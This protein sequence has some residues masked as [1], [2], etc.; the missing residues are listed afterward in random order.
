MSDSKEAEA[1]TG[2]EIRRWEVPAIDGNGDNGFLTA[3]RMQE[4]QQQAWDEAYAAGREEGLK[5][6]AEEIGRR[7]E[8]FD[9]L[10]NA[11]SRPF[12][13]LDEVVEK[14]LVELAMT[15]VRQLF[16]R[17][18]KI[19]P[20]H[21]IGVVRD[22]IKLLPVASRNIEVHLHPE[23]AALVRE[24]LSPAEGDRAWAIVE[25]PLISR[26]GCRI[27][28]DNSQVDA[29]AETRLNAIIKAINGDE[30]Q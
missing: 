17:E 20:G 25:D 16:R 27:T 14:Q 11:L 12:D 18:L 28:T 26:G 5:A 6:G 21:V 22:A 24:S 10:L 30:R 13:E 4:L 8:R 1:T 3:G 19:D 23:D 15:V 2:P 9:Q 29:R 7:A